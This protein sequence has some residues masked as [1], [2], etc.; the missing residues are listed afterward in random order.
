V[1]HQFHQRELL[2][3]QGLPPK[4]RILLISLPGC[5]KTISAAAI[6]GECGL[7]LMFVQLHPLITKHMGETTAK[8]HLIFEAMSQT[9]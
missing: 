7:S 2:R 4:R 3:S 1:I 9:R 5:G 6:S 8:L